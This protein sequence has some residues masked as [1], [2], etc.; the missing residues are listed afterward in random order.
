MENNIVTLGV[1]FEVKDAAIYGGEGTVG[2]ANTHVDLKISSLESTNVCEYV[3]CQRKGIAQM[4]KVD[5][6]KVRVISK[7]EYDENT[8]DGE[9]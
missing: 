1:Y 9:V 5:V 8:E 3:E 2:Y 4:C 6:E 7:L